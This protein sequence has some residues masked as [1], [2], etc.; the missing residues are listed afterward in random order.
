MSTKVANLIAIELGL[1]IAIMGWVGFVRLPGAPPSGNSAWERPPDS[2]ASVSPLLQRTERR[3]AMAEEVVNRIATEQE[4]L[5]ARFQ[6]I[7][8]YEEVEPYVA[9]P[10]D[11]FVAESLP[12]DA[13]VAQ[14]PALEESQFFVA[15]PVQIFQSVQA[16]Q[17]IIYSNARPHRPRRCALPLPSP[18]ATTTTVSHRPGGG[19][20]RSRGGEANPRQSPG[21]RVDNAPRS[22]AKPGSSGPRQF[23]VTQQHR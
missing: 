13:P 3:L 9:D 16:S 18:G 5:E 21:P 15:P 11:N 4:R 14:Q 10:E 17:I 12:Y 6:A 7:P 22:T 23:V 8:K 2:F 19:K 1:L 20:P